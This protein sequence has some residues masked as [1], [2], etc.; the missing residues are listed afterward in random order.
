MKKLL[1]ISLV[2]LVVILFSINPAMAAG[3]CSG[4]PTT[5]CNNFKKENTCDNQCEC[6]WDS[7]A[8]ECI[9]DCSGCSSESDCKH[10][11]TWTLE[12]EG[13]TTSTTIIPGGGGVQ[14]VIGIFPRTPS[15]GEV[16]YSETVQLKTEIFF[17]GKPSNGASVKAN[18]S[19]FGELILKHERSLPDGIYIANVTIKDTESGSKKII[20]TA[21]Q[22]TQYNEAFIFVELKP[23]L[24]IIT[25]VDSLYYKD[26]LMKFNGTVFDKDKKL[27]SNSLVKISG[28]QN[29]N[30]IFYIETNTDEEGNFYSDYLVKHGDPEGNWKILI[31]AES[32]KKEIGGK[33]LSTQISVPAGVSYY[34]VNFL[35]PLK[36]KTFRRGETISVTIEVKDISEFV[37]GASVI[38]Y[39]P[40]EESIILNEVGDGKY[41]GGYLIKPNDLIDNW[42]LKAEVK[43]QIGEIVKVGGA[44][45]PITVNPAEIKFNILSPGSDV[46]YT[47]SRLKIKIK[48]TYPDGSLVKGADLNAVLLDN[49]EAI[50]LREVS[51]GIYEGSRFVG[52]KDVGTLIIKIDAKDINNNVGTLNQVLFVRKRSFVGNILAFIQDL[53]KQYWWAILTFL[54]AVVLIYMPNF[55]IS[56]IRRKIQKSIEEQ[57]NLKAMQIETEKRYYKEGVITKKEFK[58]IMGKYE[59]R[60]VKAKENEKTY[61]EELIQKLNTIKNKEKIKKLFDFYQFLGLFFFFRLLQDYF[62]NSVFISCIYF[63]RIYFIR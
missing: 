24:E 9:A 43:K 6:S 63:I 46:T 39:P 37:N 62:Q 33:S 57:R 60:M 34:S 27:K 56:W 1:I 12:E 10:G 25:N 8:G 61:K 28:Y 49:N 55:E 32:E 2:F 47:N 3:I 51:D 15:V 5:D 35:S 16:L 45:I 42:F 54:I 30:R 50:P 41:S 17:A 44:N 13:G 29:E 4:T 23:S 7:D 36:E 22:S 38:I 31:E 20:Y 14:S 21:E 18:S 26:S 52:T 53:A 11:C 19:M 59:E 40:S 58:D 48:L